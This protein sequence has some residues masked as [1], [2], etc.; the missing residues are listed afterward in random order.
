MTNIITFFNTLSL[1]R[2]SSLGYGFCEKVMNWD[3]P[4]LSKKE[5]CDKSLAEVNSKALSPL[6]LK[7]PM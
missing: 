2:L 4:F 5:N 7:I 1:S 6:D 3:T